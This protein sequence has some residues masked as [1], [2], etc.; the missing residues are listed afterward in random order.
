M[1]V[2]DIPLT[3]ALPT[4]AWKVLAMQNLEDRLKATYMAAIKAQ[5]A[6]CRIEIRVSHEVRSLL[7]DFMRTRTGRD[8]G[9]ETYTAW[10]FPVDTDD[11]MVGDS[12]EVHAVTTI[13]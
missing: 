12:I 8:M 3:S 13:H 4:P 2:T 7:A 6:G 11:A 1:E 10:G 9:V 5:Q